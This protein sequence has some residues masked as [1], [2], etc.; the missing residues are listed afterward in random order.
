VR[1][2]NWL[3]T[4][5]SVLVVV[6]ALRLTM[7]SWLTRGWTPV[8]REEGEQAVLDLIPLAGSRREM[9]DRDLQPGF[10]GQF[11]QLPLPQPHARSVA[12]SAVRCN[13]S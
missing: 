5:R 11:L 3:G 9:A 6:A 12:A 1:V 8:P 13:Q 10:V 4:R 7:T 2:S